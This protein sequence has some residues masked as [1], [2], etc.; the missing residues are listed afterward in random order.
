MLKSTKIK[1]S[2][3]KPSTRI[4]TCSPELAAFTLLMNRESIIYP[5]WVMAAQDARNSCSFLI[6]LFER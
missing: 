6:S 1:E 3:V 4:K 5:S 2:G